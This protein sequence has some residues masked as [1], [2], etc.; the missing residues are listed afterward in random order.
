MQLQCCLL[1]CIFGGTLRSVSIE[2]PSVYRTK[3]PARCA[4]VVPPQAV[5]ARFIVR[6]AKSPAIPMTSNFFAIQ[7]IGKVSADLV[8]G[9]ARRPVARTSL[10]AASACS[11]RRPRPDA[12]NKHHTLQAYPNHM[13][14]YL[15]S[16]LLQFP[17]WP[18]HQRCGKDTSKAR[19][20]DAL[21]GGLIFCYPTVARAWRRTASDSTA[22]GS[23]S[24]HRTKV[25]VL[26]PHLTTARHRAI[27]LLC[28]GGAGEGRTILMASRLATRGLAEQWLPRGHR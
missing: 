24:Q 9:V 8:P 25:L 7:K 28:G 19:G 26:I 12:Y 21:K 1:A 4:F 13:T 22:P 20:Y 2:N 16:V 3:P 27:I 17:P 6:K 10:Q 11:N 5:R 18:H 23:H 15:P 14:S